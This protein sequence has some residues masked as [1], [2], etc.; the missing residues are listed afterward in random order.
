[1]DDGW[2]S[3]VLSLLP[4]ADDDEHAW[5]D[6]ERGLAMLKDSIET[7]S[8][9]S[10]LAFSGRKAFPGGRY[11]GVKVQTPIAQIGESM[12][13]SFAKLKE[14]LKTR[15]IKRTGICLAIYHKWDIAKGIADYTAAV[16]VGDGVFHGGLPEGFVSGAIPACEAETVR[17]TGPYRYLGNAWSAAMARAKGLK[18]PC[19][20][21]IDDFEIY[22]NEAGKVRDNDLVTTIYIPVK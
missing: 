10:K 7:G 13:Q 5:G 11:I 9:P 21:N 12:D 22:E 4:Q 6:Y 14:W 17:H 15:G 16:F 18:W 20:K 1:L 2:F 8:V 19:D 3:P